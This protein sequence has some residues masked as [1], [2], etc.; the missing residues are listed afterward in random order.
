MPATG[1]VA[2][3][4]TVHRV[5]PARPAVPLARTAGE[6]PES[7][8]GATESGEPDGWCFPRRGGPESVDTRFRSGNLWREP[9]TG[10]AGGNQAAG[11]VESSGVRLPVRSPHSRGAGAA[12]SRPGAGSDVASRPEFRVPGRQLP[13][14]RPAR[15]GV[16]N[17]QPGHTACAGTSPIRFYSAMLVSPETSATRNMQ[18]Q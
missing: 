15:G 9:G 18:Q 2:P 5:A 3:I 12:G 1:F 16:V 4:V 17:R 14:A 13:G 8:S 10:S 11:K 6:P 7:W